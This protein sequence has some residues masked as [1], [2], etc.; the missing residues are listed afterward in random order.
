MKDGGDRDAAHR[1]DGELE[2]MGPLATIILWLGQRPCGRAIAGGQARR[3]AVEWWCRLVCKLR[4]TAWTTCPRV[5]LP[6][7]F[8]R[9]REK[10]WGGVQRNSPQLIVER[11]LTRLSTRGKSLLHIQSYLLETVSLI[12]G[13]SD[14]S[15]GAAGLRKGAGLTLAPSA[16]AWA[17]PLKGAR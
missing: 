17:V 13:C 4:E 6:P 10:G 5:R 3:A 9:L 11:V 16:N 2:I 15:R 12:S 1:K 14:E 8:P 7:A